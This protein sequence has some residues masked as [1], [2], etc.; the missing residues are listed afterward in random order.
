MNALRLLNPYPAM[1]ELAEV[2]AG[3]INRFAI[4]KQLNAHCAAYKGIFTVFFTKH[5]PLRNLDEVKSCDTE[6]FAAFFRH[7]LKRGFYLSPSQFE[8][9][10]ISAAHTRAEIDSAAEAAIEFLAETPK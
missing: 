9:N 8:L 2:F 1:A 6:M 4:E 10:F 7:M 5:S 3:K